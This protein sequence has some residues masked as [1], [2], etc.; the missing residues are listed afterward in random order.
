VK[1]TPAVA[2]MVVAMLECLDASVYGSHRKL[3]EGRQKPTPSNQGEGYFIG[4]AQPDTSCR[5]S[6][7]QELGDD[8]SIRTDQLTGCERF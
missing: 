6:F 7:G 4:P 1:T 2:R 3:G 5:F 8:I